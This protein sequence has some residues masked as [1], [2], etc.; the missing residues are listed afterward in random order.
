MKLFY[1][2]IV[3][4]VSSVCFA[5]ETREI[6]LSKGQKFH[7]IPEIKFKILI[8]PNNENYTEEINLHYSLLYELTVENDTNNI[9]TISNVLIKGKASMVYGNEEITYDSEKPNPTNEFSKRIDEVLN[10]PFYY[11]FQNGCCI[12]R[13]KDDI[14]KKNLSYITGSPDLEMFNNFVESLFIT[15]PINMKLNNEFTSKNKYFPSDDTTSYLLYNVEKIQ[16]N[17]VQLS[18]K[19]I[20]PNTKKDSKKTD[21]IISEK[22]KGKATVDINTGLVK[23]LNCNG[24]QKEYYSN[25]NN[26][27]VI[28]TYVDAKWTAEEIK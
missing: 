9:F 22:L 4:I 28:E 19:G 5:Q 2:I 8:T 25:G 12:K 11:T 7:I 13:K 10:E 14:K 6:V 16:D 3:L 27:L 23:K 24:F 18:F 26:K 20:Q 15:L 21:N 1:L 17:L